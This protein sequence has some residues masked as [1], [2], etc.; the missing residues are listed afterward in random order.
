MSDEIL[1]DRQIDGWWDVA[2]TGAWKGT[3][4]GAPAVIE[5]TAAD[6]MQMA[7]D[8]DPGL[9]EAPVTVEHYRE[10]PAHGWVAALRVAGEV[11]Q[12]RFHRLSGQLRQWLQSGAY[13]SRSIEMYKPFDLTGRAYL[14]AVSFL[15]AAPPAVKGL[16]PLP[17]LLADPGPGPRL[18]V[19]AGRITAGLT[20]N[21]GET[22]DRN[23]LA[24]RALG[25]LKGLIGGRRETTEPES[26]GSEEPVAGATLATLREELDAE[27][28]TRRSAEA[29]L[30]ELQSRVEETRRQDQLC[31]FSAAL[32]QAGEQK[33]LTPAEQK[34]YESLGARLDEDGRRLI[35]EEISARVPL[36][37]FEELSAPETSGRDEFSRSRA[38][39][40]GFPEDPEH[41]EALELMAAE[42]GLS[43]ADA[44]RRVRATTQAV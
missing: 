43:F 41:D 40:D 3:L 9:Q 11:L 4:A 17:S 7:E 8:Y 39:F 37:L 27:R 13:R 33:R 6:L 44:I 19:C 38:Q 16:S 2:R 24:E 30:A 31:A 18:I 12:A 15:G 42:P 14:G 34:G 32:R 25:S 5:I 29:R 28:V 21:G 20:E 35:L 1:S 26:A 23:N 10:G 22:M 36:S